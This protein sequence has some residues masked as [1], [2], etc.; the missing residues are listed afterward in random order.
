LMIGV[1]S[2]YRDGDVFDALR[3]HVLPE[4]VQVR[5][6]PDVWSVA[7]S[8]GAE[9]L[10]MAAL[11]C[12]VGAVPDGRLRGTDCRPSAIARA[13]RGRYGAS[14]MA[15]M[16][17]TLRRQ[18]FS[19]SVGVFTPAGPLAAATFEW[20]VEDALAADSDDTSWDIILCRNLAIYLSATAVKALWL[21]LERQ[22]R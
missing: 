21:R 14:A 13:R 5:P 1:T 2:F 8:D 10:S 4:L 18:C 22:L 7:C 19:E 15:T 11:L 20:Q 3:R 12:E 16:P 9:L 17:A 6:A